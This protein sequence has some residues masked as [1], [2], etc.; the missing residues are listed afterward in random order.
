MP[1][2]LISGN[3]LT[4]SL[5]SLYSYVLQSVLSARLQA[6]M[7]HGYGLKLLATLKRP[8]KW[9]SDTWTMEDMTK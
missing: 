1:E 9:S 8:M 6:W 2:V 3:P 5:S 4:L 7:G